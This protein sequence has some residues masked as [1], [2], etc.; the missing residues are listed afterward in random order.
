MTIEAQFELLQAL[1][2]KFDL[3]ITQGASLSPD[4]EVDRDRR[5]E[6]VR[7]LLEW[8]IHRRVGDSSSRTCESQSG[9]TPTDLGVNRAIRHNIVG[10]MRPG[11]RN[12]SR[13]SSTR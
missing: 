12:P 3:E 11:S 6:A 7:P 10:D 13:Q 1:A 4:P 8:L 2:H 5:I 9:D